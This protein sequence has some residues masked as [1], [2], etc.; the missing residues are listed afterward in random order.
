[1]PTPAPSDLKG[2][3]MAPA[4]MQMQKNAAPKKKA[5]P[6]P[7]KPASDPLGSGSGLSK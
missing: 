7:S 2:S 4:P 3:T 1:M 5:D 6:M